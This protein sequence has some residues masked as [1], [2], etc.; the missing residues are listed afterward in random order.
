LN[1]VS[2][3]VA[4]WLV[5]GLMVLLLFNLLNRQEARDPEVIFS[6]FLTCKPYAEY[7]R[8][9]REPQTSE[10]SQTSGVCASGTLETCPQP[11]SRS[12]W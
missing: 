3:N 4:L 12:R 1:Q 11:R 8:R 9:A 6:E 2:R 10:V 5:L 7:L